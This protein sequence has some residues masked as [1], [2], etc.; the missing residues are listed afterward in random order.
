M[1][2]IRLVWHVTRERIVDVSSH[3]TFL[4]SPLFVVVLELSR[5]ETS[6][7]RQRG[8]Y[9]VSSQINWIRGP[10][11]NRPSR[12]ADRQ[13]FEETWANMADEA[14]RKGPVRNYSLDN[15]GRIL[16]SAT[17]E[18]TRRIFVARCSKKLDPSP[19]R[20]STNNWFWGKTTLWLRQHESNFF[21]G[22]YTRSNQRFPNLWTAIEMK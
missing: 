8:E 13:K 20:L 2:F 1:N 16:K 14:D 6:R 22:K 11:G 4:S 15:R 18:R 12:K 3:R 7:K 5:R 9:R 21:R 17:M 19:R 10:A